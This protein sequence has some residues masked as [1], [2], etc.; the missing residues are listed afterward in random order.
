MKRFEKQ[1]DTG[2]G[3]HIVDES[4]RNYTLPIDYDPEA[5]K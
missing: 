1:K 4:A 5:V 2:L 3:K